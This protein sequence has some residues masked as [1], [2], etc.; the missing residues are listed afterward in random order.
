MQTASHRMQ[1]NTT[2]ECGLTVHLGSEIHLCLKHLI[3]HP[4]MLTRLAAVI[5]RPLRCASLL[6]A[7]VN[8]ILAIGAGFA[9]ETRRGFV[10]VK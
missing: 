7:V 2:N 1:A 9:V 3:Q 10:W 4:H 5:E 8:P 6:V